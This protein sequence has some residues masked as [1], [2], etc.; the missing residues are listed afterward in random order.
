[1]LPAEDGILSPLAAKD[2]TTATGIPTFIG[3]MIGIEVDGLDTEESTGTPLTFSLRTDGASMFGW[4][5]G[6]MA[7]G[8]PTPIHTV[9]L[10]RRVLS[11]S[12]TTRCRF[13]FPRI[14]RRLPTRR[15]IACWRLILI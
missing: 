4:G 13:T 7:T 15:S 10:L 8:T 12:T 9:P 3:T 2:R 1:M 6:V 5:H 14:V 11:P